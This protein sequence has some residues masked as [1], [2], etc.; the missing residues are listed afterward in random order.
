M[1]G[2]N[3]SSKHTFSYIFKHEI[4]KVLH[5]IRDWKL[6]QEIIREKLSLHFDKFEFLI[7]DKT[8]E[9][10][11]EFKVETRGIVA[12]FRTKEY[13]ENPDNSKI[14]W[15]IYKC[16]P[17]N[18]EYLLTCSLFRDVTNTYTTVI[19]VWEYIKD[20]PRNVEGAKINQERQMM[21]KLFD[22][23]LN[24]KYNL[25]KLKSSI[26]VGTTFEN[27]QKVLCDLKL[28]Q[29]KIPILCSQVEY[30]GIL[31]QDKKVTFITKH[32]KL[33]AKAVLKVKVIK[34]QEKKFRILYELIE[35]EPPVPKQNIEWRVDE[36]G[37]LNCKIKLI[38]Y[39]FGDVKDEVLKTSKMNKKKILSYLKFY[40]ENL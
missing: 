23:Y 17:T 7:G 25:Q 13:L 34:Q 22:D 37:E 31:E 8:W 19:L 1:E 2:L 39:Y 30:E 28:L 4:N 35:S 6:T 27:A 38:H 11:N 36:L 21:F 20:I 32:E 40:L 14:Q 24:A 33:F 16:E 18:L 10:G 26:E 3:N 12:Y 5:L 29:S 15:L 9:V